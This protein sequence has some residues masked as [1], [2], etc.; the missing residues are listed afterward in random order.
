MSDPNIFQIIA[1]GDVDAVKTFLKRTDSEGIYSDDDGITALMHA[2]T[3]DFIEA[4]RL[5]VDDPRCTP[6]YVLRHCYCYS[7]LKN[8]V[9]NENVEILSLLLDFLG[10]RA[11]ASYTDGNGNNYTI[12][13]LAVINNHYVIAEIILERCNSAMF[14]SQFHD[15]RWNLLSLA[16][17]PQMLHLL[18]QSG[19]DALVNT[20]SPAT[21]E[22]PYIT[23]R[24]LKYT[25]VSK[26]LLSLTEDKNLLAEDRA[27]R[28]VS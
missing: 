6:E 28:Y 2:V 21:G 27:T 7:A 11:Y 15:G 10:D 26:K 16:Q 25:D 4:V 9:E 5:I 18:L 20:P 8:A 3:H 12:L 19:A 22:M 24:K 17:T 14:L 23:A 13:T 1:S